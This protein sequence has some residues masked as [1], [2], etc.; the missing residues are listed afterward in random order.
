MQVTEKIIRNNMQIEG[1]PSCEKG[2]RSFVRVKDTK[3][4]LDY[5]YKSPLLKTKLEA[6]LWLPKVERPNPFKP[7][8]KSIRGK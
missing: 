6:L 3:P 7:V 4:R 1:S 8:F 5:Y 2:F